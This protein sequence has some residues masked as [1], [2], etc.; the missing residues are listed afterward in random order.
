MHFESYYVNPEDVQDNQLIILGDELHH[1][2]RVK[3]KRIG[4]IIQVVDGCGKAYESEILEISKSEAQCK[5][6]SRQSG[7]GE[8]SI[9]LT[10]VQGVLKGD[11]FDWFVE[12]A[13]EI[14]IRRII[15]LTCER[16]VLNP[17]SNKVMRWN[18]IA[19]SAMKQCGR[20]V[21]P[22]VTE[23][24]TMEE[25]LTSGSEYPIQLI[26][27]AGESS[28][29]SSMVMKV[30]AQPN[31]Q[32]MILV[33]PEGGFTDEEVALAVEQGFAPVSLGPRRL[34]A[35]TAGIV[36]STLIMSQMKELE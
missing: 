11:R 23:P 26:A 22:E 34:R 25:A 24:A 4:D 12:K 20:C 33:G 15:P 9:S 10:V 27:H 14:G 30:N 31:P 1:L 19:L 16:A 8:A 35:E 7:M 32:I 18:R 3:R 6:L 21:L 2:A 36:F 17:G 29:P 5:I 28:H 13:T